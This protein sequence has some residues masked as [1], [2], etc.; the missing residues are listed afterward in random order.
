M[1]KLIDTHA[2]LDELENVDLVLK[3]AEENG[4]VAIVAVGSDYQSNM[5]TL[6]ISQKHY[7]FVYPALGLH[8]W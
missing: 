6:E 7:S 5:K 1:Y 4:R 3:E 8:P 2:H